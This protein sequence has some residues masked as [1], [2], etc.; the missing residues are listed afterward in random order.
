MKTLRWRGKT[1]PRFVLC[2]GCYEPIWESVWVIPGWLAV[3]GVC[4]SCRSW[5]SV[6]DLS[7]PKPGGK[8]D[9]PGGLCPDCCRMAA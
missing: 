7:S 5:E 4:V 8:G 1:H 6:R 9:A 2:D 3:W